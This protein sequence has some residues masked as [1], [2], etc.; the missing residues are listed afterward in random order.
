[1]NVFIKELDKN[2]KVF[3][4]KWIRNFLQK[5][6]IKFTEMTNNFFIL[7]ID[8]ENKIFILPNI[9]KEDTY[10]NIIKKIKSNKSKRKI[11]LILS[12]SVKKY[13][14]YLKGVR[15][16]D[17]RN[18]LIDNIENIIKII[19]GNIP[20]EIIDLYILANN[21]T[22]T[23][24]NFIKNISTKVKSVNLI[25]NQIEK[26]KILEEMLLEEGI[27]ISISNN[28]RKSLKN[29]KFIIDLDFDKDDI[30]KYNINRNA[31]IINLSHETI[32]D[33]V[34]G[35]EGVII[36]SIDMNIS[37]SNKKMLKDNNIYDEFEKIDLYEAIKEEKTN[38]EITE[39]YGCNGKINEKE[40]LNVRKILTNSEN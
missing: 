18:I 10:I 12:K 40:L 28:K 32:M 20:I 3:K 14:K 37:E 30:V 8:E 16:L 24:V 34:H 19:I 1:M 11:D 35:F 36:K 38:I 15:I 33:N 6:I 2:D 5:I 22:Q 13:D 26:Y 27:A 9:G 21:Y 23:N 39:L 7:N 31:C 4:K 17:G 29:A 25:T